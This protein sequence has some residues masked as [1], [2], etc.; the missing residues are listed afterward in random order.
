MAIRTRGGVSPHARVEPAVDLGESERP[1]QGVILIVAD[2][3][4]RD[5]LNPWGYDRDTSPALAKLASEGALFRDNITQATWTKVS[6]TSI[7]T[8]LYPASHRVSDVA[9]RLPAAAQTLAEVYR[10]A[11]YATVSYSS[12]TFSGKLTNLHQG[13]EELHERGSLDLGDYG[14]KKSREYVDRLSEWLDS[15]RDEPFF[16]FLHVFDPHS[17]FEPRRPYNTVWSDPAEREGFDQMAEKLEK[18]EDNDG[19][20]RNLV[21]LDERLSGGGSRP[22]PVCHLCTGLV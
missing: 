6:V 8:S 22:R 5:H 11:G 12:V 3:L 4:R 1:P 17:P 13:F 14:T 19:R 16:V 21:F 7:L 9:D 10:D 20:G 2:K 15:H 18:V